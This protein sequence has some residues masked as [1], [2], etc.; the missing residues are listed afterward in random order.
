MSIKLE[1][2]L[3]DL[4]GELLLSVQLSCFFFLGGG[5]EGRSWCAWLN[6]SQKK[7]INKTNQETWEMRNC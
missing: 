6:A 7:K 3:L 1:L 5:E 4:L 2:K